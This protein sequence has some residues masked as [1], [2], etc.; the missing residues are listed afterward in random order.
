MGNFGE[1]WELSRTLG[2]IG[3]LLRTLGNFGD[4]LRTLG[5]FGG[6][7]K[8]FW[9][10]RR[11]LENFEELWGTLEVPKALTLSSQSSNPKLQPNPTQSSNPTHPRWCFPNLGWLHSPLKHLLKTSAANYQIAV[12]S[13]MSLAEFHVD[14]NLP[15]VSQ[16]R[17]HQMSLCK[18]T[19]SD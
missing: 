16:F 9:E 2:N 7:L 1:L 8:N 12:Y 5:N 3:E 18:M 17:V 4:F 6:T 11:L 14:Q 15:L 10:L 13:K 19:C